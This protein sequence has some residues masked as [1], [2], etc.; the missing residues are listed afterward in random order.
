MPFHPKEMTEA[1]FK[2]FVDRLHRFSKATPPGI[3]PKRSWSQEAIARALG[4][5]NFHAAHLALSSDKPSVPQSGKTPDSPETWTLTS[6][7]G[8]R[9]LSDEWFD[10]LTPDRLAMDLP[11]EQLENHALLLG[12]EKDRQVAFSSLL[13]LCQARR[14]PLLWIQGKAAVPLAQTKGVAEYLFLNGSMY[15][16]TVDKVLK[17]ESLENI[18]ASFENLMKS[19]DNSPQGI[20]ANRCMLLLNAVLPILVWERDHHCKTFSF[21]DIQ[22]ASQLS[23]LEN[24]LNRK[25]LPV[26]GIQHY[27]NELPGYISPTKGKEKNDA[28]K[29]SETVQMHHLHLS[30]QIRE[31]VTQ[32][33][34]AFSSAGPLS[35]RVD[36]QLPVSLR[37]LSP[38]LDQWVQSHENGIV[39]MDGLDGD[40]FLYE[41]F[42]QS[43][44]KLEARDHKVALGL[45]CLNDLP[46]APQSQRIV[47]RFGRFVVMN[48]PPSASS[49]ILRLHQRLK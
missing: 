26:D 20:W 15:N 40:S 12:K 16:L 45:R 35:L 47:D 14:T 21:S 1:T 38:F 49:D 4:F 18:I 46:P 34:R 43:L 3:S 25:D 41:W 19:H 37:L 28:F 32:S 10:F 9:G 29:Q 6:R 36:A 44:G 2:G 42:L 8:F 48:G 30:N 23:N 27:L 7:A 17:K 24:W 22:N 31:A 13:A 39:I 33:E 11:L 5:S